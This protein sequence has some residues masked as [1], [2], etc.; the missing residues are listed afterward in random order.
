MAAGHW[1]LGIF[2]NDTA[3][4]DRTWG[5]LSPCGDL[6]VLIYWGGGGGIGTPT[7]WL[8]EGAGSYVK[9]K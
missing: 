8:W 1:K 3:K 2:S 7:I 6:R 9:N 4:M 5:Y